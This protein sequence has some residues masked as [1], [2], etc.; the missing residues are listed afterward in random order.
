MKKLILISGASTGIGRAP[1]LKLAAAGHSVLAGIRSQAAADALKADA[2]GDLEPVHLDIANKESLD[3]FCADYG[4]RLNREG[5]AGLVNNAGLV[6]TSPLE[7]MPM[8]EWREMF[9]VNVF[10]HVDLTQRML[11]YVR[12]VKG[13]VVF[14]SSASTKV[15]LPLG[16][17]YCGAKHALE[18]IGDS[19]RRELAP[20]GVSVSIIEPGTIETPMLHETQNEYDRAAETLEGEGSEKYREI[21]QGLS[22]T[23]SNFASQSTPPE[24]VAEAIAHALFARKPKIRYFVGNDAKMLSALSAITTD[25]VMDAILRKLFHL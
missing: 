23:I 6:R 16:T 1:A 4:E 25:R 19:L 10:G 7:L 2:T 11:R 9:G 22:K 13:R 5:L 21:A 18:G 14:T 20:F 3:K 12:A 17:S 15:A 24:K 8:S